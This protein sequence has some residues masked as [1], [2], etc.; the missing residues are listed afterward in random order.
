MVYLHTPSAWRRGIDLAGKGLRKSFV[1][2][3]LAIRTIS[4]AE[5][6]FAS[7]HLEGDLGHASLVVFLVAETAT[8]HHVLLIDFLLFWT[9]I[10]AKERRSCVQ[11]PPTGVQ[12][13]VESGFERSGRAELVLCGPAV[14]AYNTPMAFFLVSEAQGGHARTVRWRAM[15]SPDRIISLMELKSSF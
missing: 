8:S 3:S 10:W 9:D 6:K 12:G 15:L 5:S 2:G 14:P 7:H 13:V 11:R 1:T 4:T